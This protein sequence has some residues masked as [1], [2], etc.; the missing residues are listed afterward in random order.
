M[1]FNSP[2]VSRAK[3]SFVRLCFIPH[4]AHTNVMHIGVKLFKEFTPSLKMPGTM[5]GIPKML[6][7]ILEGQN[8]KFV[9]PKI[10]SVACK[11]KHEFESLRR[12]K[13][14]ENGHG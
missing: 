8:N 11:F 5:S 4:K 9:M 3:R 13:H 7:I 6:V 14:F 10:T 12:M 1:I 2:S